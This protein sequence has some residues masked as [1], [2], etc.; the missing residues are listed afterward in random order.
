[1]MDTVWLWIV[2]VVSSL[3]DETLELT[4]LQVVLGVL[5]WCVVAVVVALGIGQAIRLNEE[6]ARERRDT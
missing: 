1:M 4:V 3:W 5:V 2:E 6:A